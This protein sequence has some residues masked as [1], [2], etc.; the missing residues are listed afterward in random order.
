MLNKLHFETQAGLTSKHSYKQI[1]QPSY[2]ELEFKTF[3]SYWNSIN[4]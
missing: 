2:L 1:L 3:P 4:T